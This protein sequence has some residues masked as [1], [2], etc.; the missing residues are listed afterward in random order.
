ML[1]WI[2]CGNKINKIEQII[3]DFQYFLPLQVPW[4]IAISITY[5]VKTLICLSCFL[6]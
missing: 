2:K 6:Y 4:A 5:P 3:I 1:D